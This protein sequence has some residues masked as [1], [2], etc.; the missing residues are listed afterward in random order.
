MATADHNKKIVPK[1]PALRSL[2]EALMSDV[3]LNSQMEN[4]S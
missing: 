3:K 4:E 2:A 1:P